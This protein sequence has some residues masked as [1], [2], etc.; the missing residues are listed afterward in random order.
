[1][2][3]ERTSFVARTSLGVTI[4]TFASRALAMAWWDDAREGAGQFP[5]CSIAAVTETIIIRHRVIR[6]DRPA[7]VQSEPQGVAA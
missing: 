5:G 3:E 4:R 1:M 7:A 6:R 2:T